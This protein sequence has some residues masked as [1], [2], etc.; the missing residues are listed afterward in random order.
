VSGAQKIK[1]KAPSTQW[2]KKA[3]TP[4]LSAVFVGWD[5]GIIRDSRRRRTSSFVINP[6]SNEVGTECDPEIPIFTFDQ[7]QQGS[8]IQL[9]KVREVQDGP[10]SAFL[11]GMNELIEIGQMSLK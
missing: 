10:Q 4:G 5:F 7:K 2:P 8:A 11:G 3:D 1:G 6:F 9:L